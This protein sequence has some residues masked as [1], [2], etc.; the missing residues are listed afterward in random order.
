MKIWHSLLLSLTMLVAISPAAAQ[1]EN[2][3]NRPVRWT[4]GFPPG[5]PNDV[6]ARL[7]AQRLSDRLGQPFVIESR[8]GAGS[9]I[10]TQAVVNA[11][12]DGY[13]ILNIGHFN[14]INATLYKKLPFNFIRDIVPVAGM[15]QMSNVL[16]VHPSLPVKTVPELIAYL[17]D[18]P[19]KVSYASGGN[20]TSAHLGA[21]LF[22]VMTG[23]SM[24]HVPYRGA[25]AVL[26]DLLP[27]RVQAYINI[28]QSSLQQIRDG[29]LRALAVT[30]ATRS[31]LLPDVPTI[32]ET[33]PGFEVTTWY[34]IGVPKGTPAAIVRKLNSEVNA[35]L[36]DPKI[37]VRLQ[38]LGAEPFIATPEQMATYVATE[39]D[40]WGKAVTFSGASVE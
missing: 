8:P 3:P 29:Q 38:E 12:P 31:D 25:G 34:G 6:V 27:G 20:G 4:L 23:T 14:A 17:K 13:N 9:N 10:A 40:R 18:N 35:A 30:S 28:L 22:N 33:V 24:T 1:D 7:I 26:T 37:K 15:V 36:Q 16:V 21:E 5:G 39:T 19:G 2:Y 32:S 11:A